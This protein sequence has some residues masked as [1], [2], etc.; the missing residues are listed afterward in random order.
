MKDAKQ[1]KR[2]KDFL[3]LLEEAKKHI[4]GSFSDNYVDQVLVE[5]DEKQTIPF[6]YGVRVAN[7]QGWSY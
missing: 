7:T 6:P 2:E 5:D 4:K 1:I 3:D